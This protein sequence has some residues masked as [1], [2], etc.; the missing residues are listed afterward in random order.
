MKSLK[1]I[2]S[3]I[4]KEL[5]IPPG[6]KPPRRIHVGTGDRVQFRPGMGN[7]PNRERKLLGF[8]FKHPKHSDNICIA[9]DDGGWAYYTEKQLLELKIANLSYLKRRR[10][11]A[12]MIKEWKRRERVEAKHITP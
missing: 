5:G 9:W 12:S 3:E 10:A 2:R 8:V 7:R 4:N 6:Y 11:M 1:A